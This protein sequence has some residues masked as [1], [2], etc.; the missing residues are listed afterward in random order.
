MFNHI[1]F[2]TDGSNHAY[3]ALETAATL[4]ADQDA[5]LTILHVLM[6]G[7]VPVGFQRMLEV[8]N[9]VEE[10]THLQ[11]EFEYGYPGSLAAV[12]RDI[13]Y[14]DD[15]SQ[16]FDYLGDAIISDSVKR[17]K[18]LGVRNVHGQILTGDPA[19]TILQFESQNE[20]DL[21]VIAT[22]GLGAIKRILLG[23]VTSKVL[24]LSN[25]PCL[26]VK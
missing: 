26:A 13:D 3:R 5:E 9:I 18:E 15:K 20:V 11:T 8:E 23:S 24:Q 7:S 25:C 21:I 1:L 2:A 14:R 22:R 10:K 19:D 17:A 16:Y 12:L 6:H 4:T